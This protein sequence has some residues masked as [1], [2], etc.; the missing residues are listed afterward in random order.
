M[1]GFSK[2]SPPRPFLFTADFEEGKE[3][4]RDC[5]RNFIIISSSLFPF[6]LSIRRRVVV[7]SY[8]HVIM[9]S[10][11]EGLALSV[12]LSLFVEAFGRFVP[13]FAFTIRP[14]LFL[15]I[16]DRASAQVPC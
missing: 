8:S 1:N 11:S 4:D 6:P 13:D 3:K 5:V 12:A 14:S 15:S 16:G 7:H 10:G 9:S 2:S